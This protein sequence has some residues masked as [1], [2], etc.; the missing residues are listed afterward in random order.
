VLFCISHNGQS[1]HGK[2]NDDKLWSAHAEHN[3]MEIDDTMKNLSSIIEPLLLLV[4]GVVVGF[5]AL[6]LIMPI[7]NISQS[8]S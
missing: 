1:R 7:Y 2:T 5:L 4:I 3:E 6:A 8:I